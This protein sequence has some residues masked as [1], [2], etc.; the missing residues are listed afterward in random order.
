MIAELDARGYALWPSRLDR[1]ELAE[2][3]RLFS[4]WPEGRPGQRI[5]PARVARLGGVRRLCAAM[6]PVIGQGARPVRAILFDKQDGG[7]WALGWHQD[8]TIEVV[9]RREVPGFGPWTVKQGRVHVAPPVSLLER[10]VTV[11]LHLDP[12]DADNAP[13][14]VAPGSHRLGLI[15]EDAISGVV[16]RLGDDACLA[17]AGSVWLY[18]T[19]ILHASARSAPGRRRRVLQIDLSAESL[20]GG[21][22]WSTDGEGRA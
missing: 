10:M 8:R 6:V 15:A 20:P 19:P 2:L 1:G 21:L 5:D 4:D 3:A 7:N 9:E 17:G 14:L 16:D 22:S 13:L 11:R 18:R 12:V